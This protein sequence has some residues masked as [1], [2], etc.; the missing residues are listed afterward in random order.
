MKEKN[1]KNNLVPAGHKNPDSFGERVGFNL[2]DGRT[3]L[4]VFNAGFID[5]FDGH[6][7]RPCRGADIHWRC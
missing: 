2:Q 1:G 6:L 5:V 7:G 4:G 3:F